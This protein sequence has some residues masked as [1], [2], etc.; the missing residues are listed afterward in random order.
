MEALQWAKSHN[1][2]VFGEV[3]VYHLMFNTDDYKH[4]KSRLKVS[5]AI[6]TP[7]LQAR[8]WDYVFRDGLVDTICSEHTPH[9]LSEKPDD[10]QKASSGMP[11]IQEARAALVTGYFESQLNEHMPLESFLVALSRLTATNVAAIFGLTQKGEIDVNKDADL[12][13]MDIN[14]GSEILENNLFSKCGWSPYTGR[15][16]KGVPETTIL[17][18]KTIYSN[19]QFIEKPFGKYLKPGSD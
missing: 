2:T 13:I 15:T 4:L 10:V 7:E 8:L 16:L 1:Q 14:K 3:A 18:G 17:R 12:V 11:G 6:R 19:G 9:L 5:P